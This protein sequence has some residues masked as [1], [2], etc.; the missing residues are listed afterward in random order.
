MRRGRRR[1]R[2]RRRAGGVG[3]GGGGGGG[4]GA[5]ARARGEVGDPLIEHL[6]G[7]F[8]AEGRVDA[9]LVLHKGVEHTQHDEDVKDGHE[10]DD[11][12]AEVEQVADEG[13]GPEFLDAKLDVLHPE[14][15]E[16]DDAQQEELALH[17]A[18]HHLE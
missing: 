9:Q 16:R 13:A 6:L 15:H 12:V 8:F 18:K 2:A 11:V 14:Q 1:L 7:L 5:T 4:G 3:V 10:K 17:L